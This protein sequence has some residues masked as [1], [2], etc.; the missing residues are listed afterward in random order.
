[1]YKKK[2]VVICVFCVLCVPSTVLREAINR[3]AIIRMVKRKI[4]VNPLN[5]RHPRAMSNS[6]SNSRFWYSLGVMPNSSLKQLVK[7]LRL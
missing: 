6:S 5:L 4:R 7:Y 2:S 1:M 3:E